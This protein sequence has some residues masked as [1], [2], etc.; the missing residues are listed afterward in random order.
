MANQDTRF[1]Y[2]T[3][4]RKEAVARVRLYPGSGKITVNK[5]AFEDYFPVETLR[6]IVRQPILET[7]VQ[8]RYD[9]FVNVRGGGIAGQA[10]AIRHGIARALV[11]AD[12]EQYRAVLKKAGFLTRDAR[13]KERKKPGLKKARKASQFSKR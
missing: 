3:G 1:F 4:R 8:D 5:K 12:T 9:I 13:A 11:D 10:G 6:V 7:G 2:G